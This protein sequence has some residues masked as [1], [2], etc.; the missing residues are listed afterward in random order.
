MRT[1][2][3]KICMQFRVE[4]HFACHA[5]PVLWTKGTHF[6]KFW[7]P[8]HA[9]NSYGGF[10]LLNYYFLSSILN[11][12]GLRQ[13]HSVSKASQTWRSPSYYT[14]LAFQALHTIGSPHSGPSKFFNIHSS[15]VDWLSSA[16]HAQVVHLDKSSFVLA[17]S[18]GR[19][20]LHET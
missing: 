5:L 16:L 15:A 2:E 7:D 13:P 11:Y 19:S 10:G 6:G 20:V 4:C 12:H 3:G 8:T 14:R 18:F 9:I 17:L 1:W